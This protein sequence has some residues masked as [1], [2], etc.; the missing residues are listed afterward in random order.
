MN[1]GHIDST[2]EIRLKINYF[3]YLI[4]YYLFSGCEFHLWPQKGSLSSTDL[5]NQQDDFFNCS[6]IFSNIRSIDENFGKRGIIIKLTRLNIKCNKG[7]ITFSFNTS[8]LLCGKLEEIPQSDREYYF[9][10]V[11]FQPRLII[12]GKPIFAITYELVDFCYNITL[13]ARN[14]SVVINP[15]L[16]IFCN[17]QISLPY[18]YRID[19]S[20]SI[21]SNIFLQ[22]G[23]ISS[24]TLSMSSN[25]PVDQIDSF[26]SI[27]IIAADSLCEGIF[28]Q[29]WDGNK[30]NVYCVHNTTNIQNY[31]FRF[32]SDENQIRLRIW[33]RI[34]NEMAF[35]LF[36][37]AFEVPDIVRGCPFGSIYINLFC[38]TVI[39]NM[40]LD[41][42]KA[43]EECVR[44][45]GHLA[46]IVNEQ[47]MNLIDKLLMKRY[48]FC[49]SLS[50]FRNI[51]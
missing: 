41:W 20:I 31:H 21:K 17:Y 11:K 42:H 13:I 23:N 25:Q 28:L 45:G 4:N 44:R 15:L 46:S 51:C 50:N 27:P 19:V 1:F 30:S 36:Y 18:G 39:D 48:F 40:K 29:Y 33:S 32:K 16:K 9:P 8:A 7:N 6:I 10:P 35:Y 38:V 47:S 3:M 26:L 34:E 14:D 24:R 43:E 2:F 22:Q 12:V 49:F 37:T 5:Y